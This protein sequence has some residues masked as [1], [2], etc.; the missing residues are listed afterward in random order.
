MHFVIVHGYLLSGTG[1]NIYTASVAKTW[2]DMGHAVTVVCQ[3]RNAGSLEFVDECFIGTD[4]IPNTP[5]AEGTIRVVVPDIGDLLLVYVLNRYE[6]YTVKALGDPLTCTEDEI[7][8]VIDKTAIGLKKVLTQGVDRVLANH[9]LLSPVVSKRACQDTNV[10]YDVKVH[11]SSIC[12]SLKQRPELLKYAVEGLS[13]CQKIVVGTHY[14]STVMSDTFKECLQNSELSQKVIRIPPGMDPSLFQL[15]KST[16]VNQERFLANVK[17]FIERKPNGRRAPNITLPKHPSQLEDLRSAL[18]SLSDS[19]D[20][21]SVDADLL[22]RWPVIAEDEPIVCYFGAYLNTK[23]VGELLASFPHILD[24]I[25]K[26]RLLIIGYGSYR[27]QMEGMLFSFESGKVEDFISYAQA[28]DFLDCSSNQLRALFRQLSPAECQ[29]ITI[30]GMLEHKQLYE[31]LPLVSVVVVPSKASE[32][33][34]MVSVEA[35]SCGVL[36]VCNYHTGIKDVLDVVKRS[37]PQMEAI[38]HLEPRPGGSHGKADGAFLVECLPTRVIQALQFLYPN[39]YKDCEKRQ[40]VAKRL[41]KIAVEN[42]S[43]EQICAA[44]IQPHK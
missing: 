6:G 12:F 32:A 27:E 41:R 9:T 1:S 7:E 43:W 26:A 11:G 22:S 30:T 3:D 34:G 19:Y 29:R 8:S 14:I 20:Q 25:P 17:D 24:R 18:V 23:G 44:L 13:S 28:G 5:P 4:T 31:I 39:G 37:D 15:L 16:L 21:W 10:P 38:M 33:F 42:F 2:R 36:P 40:D 35:M